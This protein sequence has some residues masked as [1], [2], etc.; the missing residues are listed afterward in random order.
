MRGILFLANLESVLRQSDEQVL[1]AAA[2]TNAT[3]TVPQVNRVVSYVALLERVVLLLTSGTSHEAV[4]TEL[5]HLFQANPT[6]RRP[7]RQT[8]RSPLRYAHRLRFHKY[9]KKLA[10]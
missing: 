10:A 7:D 4:L 8:P 9:V 3:L 5:H 1:Q 6:R 2:I